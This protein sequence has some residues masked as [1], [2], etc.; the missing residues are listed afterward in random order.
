MIMTTF[1]EDYNVKY[2]I[3]NLLAWKFNFSLSAILIILVLF[4]TTTSFAYARFMSNC[5]FDCE[6]PTIWKTIYGTQISGG[7]TI[8]NQTYTIK[9]LKQEIPTTTI[10]VN[11]PLEVKL[12]MYENYGYRAITHVALYFDEDKTTSIIWD[13]NFKGNTTI[14]IIDPNE[15]IHSGNVSII[16][17]NDFFVKYKFNVTFDK[18]VETTTLVAVY[19]DEF[20]NSN[21]NYFIDAL[22]VK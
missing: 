21:T 11:K 22:R 15:I 16:Y 8:D 19:W 13:K 4:S 18:P 17:E 5:S 12:R 7:F 6:P 1:S 20:V 9:N 3:H 14:T 10:D 2:L